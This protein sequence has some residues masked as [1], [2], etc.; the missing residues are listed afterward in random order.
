MLHLYCILPA[1]HAVP[2]GCV[3]LD[4][5]QPFAI[6][7]GGLVVWATEHDS[8]VAPSVEAVR[9]HNALIAA[10]MDERVTPIPLR[11][12]QVSSD[13][14]AAAERIT[15]EAE[16]WSELLGRFAGHAEYG[17]R[18][19]SDSPDAEQD[20]HTAKSESGTEY[21]ASLAR[22]HARTTG[23][24]T[25]GERIVETMAARVGSLA[26]DT[27]VEYGSADGPL[28]TVAHLVAWTAADAYHAAM[29]EV[30]ETSGDARFL[31]TGPWPP[32]SF[33]T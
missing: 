20:V 18:V 29:R 10:A 12:G 17:V 16:T 13:R 1:G 26:G 6:Q 23:R 19:M 22:K 2:D 32:Y 27:R 31:L 33:V 7:A 3:G 14:D 9:T 25:E 15:A 8:P 24:R 28:V 30:R 4:A 21:M 5:Q 11:F